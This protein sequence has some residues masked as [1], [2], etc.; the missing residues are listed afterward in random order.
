MP[1]RKPKPLK[2]TAAQ[3]CARAR[4]ARS[5]PDGLIGKAFQI[6]AS[7]ELIDRISDM[8]PV[9]RGKFFSDRASSR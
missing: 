9:E 3:A 6:V 4:A 2:L 8:T 7:P 1:K 5:I